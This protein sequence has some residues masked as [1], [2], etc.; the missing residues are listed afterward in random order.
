[1]FAFLEMARGPETLDLS[2]VPAI[3][4]VFVRRDEAFGGALSWTRWR[5]GFDVYVTQHFAHSAAVV[6]ES[7]PSCCVCRSRGQSPDVAIVAHKGASRLCCIA[8]HKSD[9]GGRPSQSVLGI[10]LSCAGLTSLNVGTN[11]D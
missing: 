5:I 1:M 2:Y 7:A 11:V 9:Y 6:G 10:L 8:G 4:F 3:I